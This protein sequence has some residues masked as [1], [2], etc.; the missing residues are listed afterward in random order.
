M[1]IKLLSASRCL[2]QA[3]IGEQVEGH[4]EHI[5]AGSEVG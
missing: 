4:T 2:A 3:A 5:K 1:L